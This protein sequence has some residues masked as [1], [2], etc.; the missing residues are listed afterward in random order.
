MIR[1]DKNQEI[2]FGEKITNIIHSIYK[3]AIGAYAALH[4]GRVGLSE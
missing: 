2:Q 1:K 3:R 4:M